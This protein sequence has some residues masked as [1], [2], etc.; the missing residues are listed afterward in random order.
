MVKLLPVIISK[1]EL[2]SF[3]EAKNGNPHTF[4]GM[5]K[6]KKGRGQGVVVRAF[7]REAAKCVVVD[8]AGGESFELKQLAPE[9]F[10]EGS[11]A[12]HEEIF[13]YQL[14]VTLHSGEIRQFFDPYSFSASGFR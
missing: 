7:V 8:L 9:G 1:S 11:I 10:F 13:R 12:G 3:I 2:A 5:H 6:V 4:L 14:R